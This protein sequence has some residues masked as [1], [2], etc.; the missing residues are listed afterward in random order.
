MTQRTTG[1]GRLAL[2]A[3]VLL[4]A[5]GGGRDAGESGERRRLRPSRRRTARPPQR[6]RSP[7]TSWR[8][9]RPPGSIPSWACTS[10]PTSTAAR[11]G[12]DENGFISRLNPRRQGGLA[13]VHRRRPGRRRAQRAEGHG[14]RGRHALGGRHRRG[15]RLQQADRQAD[16]Q[17]ERPGRAR[18]LNDAAV[19]PDG[20]IYLTDTG[21]GLGQDGMAHPGPDRVYRIENR[22]ATTA[23]DVRRR[24]RPQRH[25]LGLRRVALRHRALRRQVDHPVGAGR[26]R[27]QDDRGRPRH[28]GRRRAVRRRSPAHHQLGRLQSVRARCRQDHQAARRPRRARP[29]SGSTASGGRIAV[30]QLT[31]NRLEFV[32]LRPMRALSLSGG[33]RRRAAGRRGRRECPPRRRPVIA[34]DPRRVGVHQGRARTRSAPTSPTPSARTRRPGVIVIHEIFGLTDWEP[35]VADRLAKEG[36]VA[37]VPDLLSRKHGTTPK[38][39][40]E[41]RKLIG[42]LEPERSHRRPRRHLRLPQQPPGGGQGRHRHHR[43]L[44]GRRAELP[45]RHQQP[46]PQRRRR[47]LRPRAR[48]RRHAAG[49]RRRC[50]A[51]TARTTPGSTPRCPR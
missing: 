45:L 48:H 12:K 33:R 26:Q 35:T 11:C 24:A 25:H 43:V 3:A 19:G 28:D 1:R 18:F 41:G 13:Q 14:D 44:L 21:V 29:T 5:C 37:I 32:D 49:S 51:S 42:D 40:D 20:A 27:G 15:P 10:W 23:L 31:E 47:L 16:R 50:S 8:R 46:E 30:P 36:F 7:W 4:A 6:S 34:H 39:E 9:R 2:G 17:R 22:K 38:D